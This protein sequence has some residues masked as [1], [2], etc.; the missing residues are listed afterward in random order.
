MSA[1]ARVLGLPN[2]H[3]SRRLKS[4]EDSLGQQLVRRTT[5]HFEL[6]DVG[7]TYADICAEAF[8]SLNAAN[9]YI[10]SLRGEPQ[11]LVRVVCPFEFGQFLSEQF[12]P[13]FIAQCPKI[14]IELMIKNRASS[15]DFASNDVFIEVGFIF[16]PQNFIRRRIMTTARKLFAAPSLAKQ[17]KAKSPDELDPAHFIVSLSE[18]GKGPAT[19]SVLVHSDTK[20]RIEIEAKSPIRTNSPTCSKKIAVAGAGICFVAPFMVKSELATGALVPLL[21]RWSS[22]PVDIHL[23]LNPE[24]KHNPKIDAVVSR[25]STRFRK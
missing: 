9:D 18:R 25:L 22:P 11:G 1:A 7:R 13:D 6:T 4:L 14:Q 10:E 23:L 17:I 3:V 19:D 5:R 12:L 8:R 15:Q 24:K 16:A 20:E 21:P 2:S